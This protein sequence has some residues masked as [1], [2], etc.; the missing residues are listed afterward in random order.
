MIK[1]LLYSL[2]FSFLFISC[3]STKGDEYF[4]EL[5]KKIDKT[6]HKQK[7]D[8]DIII[9][10][11]YNQEL[12]KY[13]ES[14]KKLYLISSKYVNILYHAEKRNEQ[15]PL[16]YDLLRLNNGKYKY[17]SI[18]ATIIWQLSLKLALPNGL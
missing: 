10:N 17:V 15:I 12:Q 4:D 18:A 11:F 8:R 1:Y 5:H 7:E 14:N 16:V 3:N 6:L 13:N 2:F 9:K